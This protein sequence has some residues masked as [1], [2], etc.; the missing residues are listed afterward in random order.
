[1]L[2]D[3]FLLMILL[4]VLFFPEKL[5]QFAIINHF[6]TIY[7][8]YFHFIDLYILFRNVAKRLNLAKG[9]KK[10]KIR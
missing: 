9:K 8:L 6:C 10:S 2:S 4:Y 3:K 5:F 1:M 7:G